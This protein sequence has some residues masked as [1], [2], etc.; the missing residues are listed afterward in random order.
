MAERGLDISYETIRRWVHKFELRYAHHI[1]KKRK[2]IS[3]VWHLHEV[4]I[5]TG[6]GRYYLWRAV[7]DEG[8]VLDV[9]V[10]RRRNKKAALKLMR[11]LLKNH[12]T[13]PKAIVTDKLKSYSAA[14]KELT[15]SKHHVMGGRSNNRAENSHLPIQRRE[16]KMQRF[17]SQKSAQKFL[18]AYGPIY[19]LF[20]FQRH[21]ISRPILKEFRQAAFEEWGAV[22][23]VT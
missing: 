9:L 8:E 3:S 13:R 6:A 10:Q 19:N 17:K 4:F 14:L 7:D 2:N 20:N 16:R 12:T 1:K 23:A 15:M 22:T 21:L 18:S 11:R 5:R